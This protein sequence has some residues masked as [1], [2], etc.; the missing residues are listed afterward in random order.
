[1]MGT[2]VNTL[3]ARGVN[4]WARFGVQTCQRHHNETKGDV[5]TETFSVHNCQYPLQT[6]DM[7]FHCRLL[8]TTEY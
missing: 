7:N 4:L 3:T 1:M 8:N 2:V 5:I 6:D